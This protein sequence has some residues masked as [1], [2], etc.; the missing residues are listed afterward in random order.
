MGEKHNSRH[1]FCEQYD[2]VIGA[3]GIKK[4][5]ASNLVCMS[6]TFGRL[7][8]IFIGAHFTQHNVEN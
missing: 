1:L 8:E 4:F 6:L 3:A 2:S 5:V 7:D